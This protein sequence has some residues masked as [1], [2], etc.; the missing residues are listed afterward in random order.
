MRWQLKLAWLLAAV[1]VAVA[2][3]MLVLMVGG[4]LENPWVMAGVFATFTTYT[5]FFFWSFKRLYMSAQRDLGREFETRLRGLFEDEPTD[6]GCAGDAGAT[7]EVL[8][9]RQDG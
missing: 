6:Q 8:P 5:L 2:V 7:P 9:D 4:F 1:F 3:T